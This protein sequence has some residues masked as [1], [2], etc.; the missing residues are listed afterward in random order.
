[1]TEIPADAVCIGESMAMLVPEDANP[2]TADSRFVLRVGGAE[3]NVAVSLARLGHRSRWVSALGADPFGRIVLDELDGAGVDTSYVVTD[4]GAPTG[5]YAKDPHGRS[6]RVHYYRRGSAASR[7]DVTSI[8]PSA[9]HGARLVHLSGTMPALSESCLRLTHAVVGDRVLGP[10]AV[11]FDVNYRPGL[12]SV[13]EAAGELA[14]IARRADIVFVGRDEAAALWG[15]DRAEEV[16]ELLP[17][18]TVLVVKDGAT[19]ASVHGQGG[20]AWADALSVPVVET[21]GAGDAFAA[22]WLSGWLRGLGPERS[23][24]LGHL[25]ASRAV[26]IVGDCP[27]LPQRGDIDRYLRH[28]EERA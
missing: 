26:Q 11:S 9:A 28:D 16:R 27:V 3:S 15:T 10:A 8:D 20:R 12:W 21:V 13:A 17:E 19:G 18:P 24:R 4:E 7:L 23:L 14:A 5:I 2:I 6:T 22:G 1:M 25:V